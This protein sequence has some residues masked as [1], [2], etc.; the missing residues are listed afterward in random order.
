MKKYMPI[1]QS[2][3][4]PIV[5]ADIKAPLLILDPLWQEQ[6]RN[7]KSEAIINL[8]TKIKNLMKENA[9]LLETEK[10]L[11]RKKQEC[12]SQIRQLTRDVHD[13]NDKDAAQATEMF[14]TAVFDINT[15][16]DDLGKK[17]DKLPKE[18]EDANRELLAETVSIIYFSMRNSQARLQALVPE[19][20]RLRGEV[21]RL[22]AE[23]IECEEEA[24]RTY[25]LLHKMVGREVVNILDQQHEF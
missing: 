3:I 21:G 15:E 17:A 5:F 1:K 4:N 8:E 7:R 19:I 9:R 6:F 25:Q 16:L 22:V 23:Q 11:I 20:E 2:R 24:A 18:L 13:Y 10:S 14:K 12:L